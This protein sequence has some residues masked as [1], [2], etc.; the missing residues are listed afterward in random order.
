[1]FYLWKAAEILK[2]V[3]KPCLITK[4]LNS[5]LKSIT[6]RNFR[7]VSLLRI[8]VSIRIFNVIN[9]SESFLDLCIL[10]DDNNLRHFLERST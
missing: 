2:R 7:K 5:L 4:L 10:S 6:L 8:Y 9:L 3:Y 1:M